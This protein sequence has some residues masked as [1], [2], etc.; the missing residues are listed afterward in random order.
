MTF[1]RLGDTV[2]VP[3]ADSHLRRMIIA[4]SGIVGTA[5]PGTTRI[6]IHYEG[7][8]YGQFETYEE[9]VH[10]AWMRHVEDAPTTAF[11]V[12]EKDELLEVGFLLLRQQP[13]DE[14]IAA[15][16][17]R[18]G[19]HGPMLPP[20]VHE[21]RRELKQPVLVIDRQDIVDQWCAIPRVIETTAEV[22][23]SQVSHP[24]V[25]NSAESV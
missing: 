21:I 23:M 14:Q 4:G 5:Q 24:R 9:R 19:Y 13:T 15:E 3:C 7:S 25:G 10:H 6:L 8:K 18:R 2:Y 17:R 1:K 16:W 12:V 22:D 11:A 20:L